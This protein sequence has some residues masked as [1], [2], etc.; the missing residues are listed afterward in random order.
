MDEW[1]LASPNSLRYSAPPDVYLDEAPCSPDMKLAVRRPGGPQPLQRA[2]MGL[3]TMRS[4]P[5]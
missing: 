1:T 5:S 2:Q 3:Q 4:E